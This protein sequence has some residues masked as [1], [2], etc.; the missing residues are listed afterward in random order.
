MHEFIQMKCGSACW[1]TTS[2]PIRTPI[3]T[4]QNG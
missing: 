3:A 4:D 1:C 2:R